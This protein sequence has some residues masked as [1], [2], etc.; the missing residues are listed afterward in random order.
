[1]DEL[2]STSIEIIRDRL[3]I[4]PGV[5]GLPKASSHQLLFTVDNELVYE[6]FFADF[7]PLN[8][9]QVYRFCQ[10]LERKLRDPQNAKRRVYF[11]T[12]HDAHKRANGAFL[13][14]AYSIIY[15]NRTPEEAY[16]PLLGVYPPFIPFRDAS[17]GICTYNLT[18]LDC[19][20]GLYK[21]LENKFFDFNNF[22]VEEYEFFEKV[23]NGDLNWIIPGKFV[24][25]SGPSN[26]RTETPDGFRTLVPEDYFSYFRKTGVTT[27]IRLNKKCYDR[28]KFVDAG[29]KHYEL[30]FVDGGTPSETILKRFLEICETESGGVAVHCKAGLGRTGSLIAC[31]MM[32]HY[33][34]TASEAIAWLRICRPGSVIGPQQYYLKEMEQ[35][36]WKQGDVFRKRLPSSGSGVSSISVGGRELTDS[37]HPSMEA[38]S[39]LQPSPVKSLRGT[40]TSSRPSSGA[41]VSSQPGRISA[42]HAPIMPVPSARMSQSVRAP[43]QPMSSVRTSASSATG[44]GRSPSPQRSVTPNS[45]TSLMRNL[46]G[47]SSASASNSQP[48]PPTPTRNATPT[49]SSMHRPPTPTRVPPSPNRSILTTTSGLQKLGIGSNHVASL[50]KRT[51]ATGRIM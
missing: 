2:T 49:S 1:M 10:L 27:I 18:I 14:S 32:K 26:T 17:F 46:P 3:Y 39:Q 20:Q 31:Y 50:P 37:D 21:A 9:G 42:N 29:F 22:D 6:P 30:Y 24:A 47:D 41:P 4:V 48:R 38:I 25:F 34:F 19:L 16:R 44:M 36:L 5:R 15:L 12:S 51:T 11:F 7:G 13:I 8:L 23:E 40:G 45:R 28:K 33:H 43:P 35:R